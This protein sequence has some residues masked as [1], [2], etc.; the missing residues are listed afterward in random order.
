M[1]G[2]VLECLTETDDG[3]NQGAKRQHSKKYNRMALL[4]C[5]VADLSDQ[6]GRS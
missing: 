4:E 3:A 1:A 2:M 6:E 5:R